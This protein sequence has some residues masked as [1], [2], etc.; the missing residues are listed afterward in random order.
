MRFPKLNK[1]IA[2]KQKLAGLIIVLA[3]VITGIT[4]LIASHAQGPY[5]SAIA[6]NG[7]LAGNA[8]PNT[9]STADGGKSVLFSSG[10]SSSSS[11]I[12]AS[13][14]NLMYKGSVFKFIGFDAYGMEGCD[15]GVAW[16]TPQLDAYFAG[17]PAN[18]M[19][20]IWA[21]E[22]WGTTVMTNIVAQATKYNQHLILSLGN[23]D[24]NCDPTNDDPNQTGEPLSFYQGGW[25]N[26]Y[27]SWVKT[28]VPMFANNPTV[29][30]WEIANE[31]GLLVSVPESTMQSYLTGAAEAIKAEA[32]NQLVESGVGYAYNM[33]S[34]GGTETDDQNAQSSPA[35]NVISFHDYSY[36]ESGSP[37]LSYNFTPAQ[38]AAKALD[39]PFIAGEAG[40]DGGPGCPMSYAQRVTWLTTKANDY[41]Q[42]IGQSGTGSPDISGIMFWDYQPGSTGECYN[43]QYMFYPGDPMISAVQNYVVP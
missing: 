42:G 30:M 31:P 25:D 26:Q 34:E 5:T 20:R 36:Q 37:V 28:I 32:P 24:G 3:V 38:E 19:T 29:A 40:V 27:V 35:I 39:K 14:T 2:T 22:Y 10:T 15:G 43:E 33:N 16:T 11:Y 41:F 17:L 6:T 1:K 12:T 18:G 9:D 13:G 21:D 4:I 7:V 23:D 8:Q